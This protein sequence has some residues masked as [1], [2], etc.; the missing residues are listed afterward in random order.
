MTTL[1]FL[2]RQTS[3]QKTESAFDPFIQQTY[4]KTST[5]Y[6]TW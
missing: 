4:T 3:Y 2:S 6:Q 5:M 1:P